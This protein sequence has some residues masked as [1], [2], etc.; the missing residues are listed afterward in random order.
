MAVLMLAVLASGQSWWKSEAFL[1]TAVNCNASATVT[2]GVDFTSATVRASYIGRPS[3]GAISV[4]FTRA[5]GS[6][7]LTVDFYFQ[8]SYDNGTTWADYIESFSVETGHAVLSGTTVKVTK[9]INLYG[10]SH[11]RLSKIVNND[12]ANNLTACNATFSF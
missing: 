9:P 5:A 8:A 4:T 1:A 7:T 3:V 2:N 10:V 12:T 11:L 6:A